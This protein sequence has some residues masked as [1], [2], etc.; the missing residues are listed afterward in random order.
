MLKNISKSGEGNWL[1]IPGV[2]SFT[3]SFELIGKSLS[4]RNIGLVAVE[5][6]D[7]FKSRADLQDVGV[8]ADLV[9]DALPELLSANTYTIVGHSFGGR[10]AYELGKRRA[11]KAMASRI[12]MIDALPKNFPGANDPKDLPLTE[13]ALLRWYISTFPPAL[14]NKF[15]GLQDAELA[16]AL[17]S[18]RVFRRDDLANFTDAMRR[19]IL[20]HNAYSPDGALS[21][22][23]KLEVIVPD[24]GVFAHL[25]KTPIEAMLKQ[26]AESWAVYPASGDHYSILKN[27]DE[28]MKSLF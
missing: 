13:E 16:D 15:N 10:I 12:I 7:V 11:D 22:H 8:V 6:M 20:A 9:I 1:C 27:T 18:S 26:T 25:E 3:S 28:I 24:A 2:G 17:V 23:A 14:L 4:A 21:N 5:L 19:Q